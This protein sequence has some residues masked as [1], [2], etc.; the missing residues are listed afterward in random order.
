MNNNSSRNKIIGV[1]NVIF[2]GLTAT[3]AIIGVI[4]AFWAVQQYKRNN[5]AQMI[6]TLLG[7][8]TE[9]YKLM[10]DKPYLQ[11]ILALP[12]KDRN[13][14]S[15][16]NQMLEII[17]NDKNDNICVEWKD[18]PELYEIMFGLKDFNNN[19]K[20]KLREVYFIAETILFDI[21]TAFEAKNY[22]LIN[23]EDYETYTGYFSE[24]GNNPIFLC[25]VYWSHKNGYITKRF[26]QDL[27]K[28]LLA[29]P[30]RKSAI[31]V[32]YPDLL[33]GDWIDRGGEVQQKILSYANDVAGE[34]R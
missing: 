22:N 32:L 31:E 19:N 4:I 6:N 23:E 14:K 34:R 11:G 5:N 25:A 20:Q 27:K 15:I 2:L 10:I 33:K 28:K 21:L 9:I 3:C 17:T 7:S 8:D 29:N 16:A 30:K 18:I 13:Y 26:A 24:I 12:P 1:F